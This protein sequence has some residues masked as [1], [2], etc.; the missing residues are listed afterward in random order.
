MSYRFLWF[1]VQQ[2]PHLEPLQSIYQETRN[3]GW[4][5][6]KWGGRAI[7]AVQ[8]DLASIQTALSLKQY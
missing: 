4:V 1:G 7:W 3:P 5:E 2:I 6:V 8:Q